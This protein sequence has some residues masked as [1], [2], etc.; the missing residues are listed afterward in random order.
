MNYANLYNIQASKT[1]TKV[2]GS[3]SQKD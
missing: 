3:P 1:L 2:T